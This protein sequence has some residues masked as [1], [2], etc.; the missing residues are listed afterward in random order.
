MTK[1][2]FRQ[3][4][5]FLITLLALAFSAN[6]QTRVTEIFSQIGDFIF[7][8][9]GSMGAYGFKFLLWIGLFSIMNYGLRKKLDEKESGVISFVI[10]LATVILI[11]GDTVIKIF[12]LYSMIV[13]ISLGV[14]VPLILF[15]VVH[16]NFNGEDFP[17]VAIRVVAY[18]TICAALFWFTDNAN[19]LLIMG[20]P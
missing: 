17:H 8:D 5:I 4:V 6:A 13:V 15:Y 14:I 10:S 19:A 16:T 12:S 11:P 9:F 18:F 3:T 2:V 7:R 1:R 20:V